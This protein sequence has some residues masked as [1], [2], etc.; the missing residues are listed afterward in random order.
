MMT[1]LLLYEYSQGVYSSRRIAC[2]CEQRVDFMVVAAHEHPDSRTI[3][4]FRKRHEAAL[5][6][7]F[8]QVLQL[9]ANAGLVKLGYVAIDG[10]K[11]RAN[12]LKP[13]R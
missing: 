5:S 10:T 6:G 9:G 11:V 12:A 2:A 3:G 1:A 8:K 4:K 13:K 7:L